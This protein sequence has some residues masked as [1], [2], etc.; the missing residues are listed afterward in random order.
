VVVD[1][2]AGTGKLTRA[3]VPSGAAVIAVEPVAAMRAVL[4]RALPTVRALAGTAEA[5]PLE[6]GTVDAV[7]VAQAFH[8][9]DGSRAL[10]Q[11]HRVLRAGGRLGLIWNVRDRQ[12]QLQRAIDEI[13]EPLRGDT[14][15]QADGKWRSAL[16]GSD[17]FAPVAELRVPFQV[18]VDPGRFVDRVGS[19]SFIAALDDRRREAVLEQVRALAEEH[20]EP[21]AYIVEAYV[22]ARTRG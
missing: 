4:A 7:V 3:L 13:I 16:A 6:D 5:L 8:W 12:Q 20:P 22:Y 14:P 10:S 2:G 19:T 17:L 11:F 1:V 9:F 18:E 21:W 15:S